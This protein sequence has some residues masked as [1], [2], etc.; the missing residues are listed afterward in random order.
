MIK[1]HHQMQKTLGD[2][3][4]LVLSMKAAVCMVLDPEALRRWEI[5]TSEALVNIVKHAKPK[6]AGA[7]IDI[8]L[9]ETPNSVVVEIFDPKGADTF[10]LRQ[11]VLDIASVDPLAEAGRGL[12]LIMQSADAVDY[13]RV[14]ERYR[15]ALSFLKTGGSTADAHR[16]K[17]MQ[18]R[19]TS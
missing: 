6:T 13:G 16:P 18:S 15:L 7:S 19:E 12:G 10:D 5:A 3:D 2:V 9:T 1:C 4:R 17:A 14:A 11:H 8:F